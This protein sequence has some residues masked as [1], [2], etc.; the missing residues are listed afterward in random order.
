MSQV[1]YFIF[2]NSAA[3]VFVERVE[4]LQYLFLGQIHILIIISTW[5]YKVV[6]MHQDESLKVTP[7]GPAGCYSSRWQLFLHV[8]LI[9]YKLNLSWLISA[10]ACWCSK[11]VG[12][13]EL[14]WLECDWISLA[15][16]L[17]YFSWIL[18]KITNKI[19][20]NKSINQT[21]EASHSTARIRS[22][23]KVF[24]LGMT[25]RLFSES[26]RIVANWNIRP[27]SSN[28]AIKF[29]LMARPIQEVNLE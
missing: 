13:I 25:R 8:C 20:R 4:H 18:I 11:V 19:S 21:M 14:K 9:S 5:L 28:S 22:S 15:M 7:R 29:Q 27:Q 17:F 2:F 23:T 1:S 6:I 24:I 3:L 10:Q 16:L 26:M 12:E